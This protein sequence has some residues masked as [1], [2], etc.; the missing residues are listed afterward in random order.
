VRV[1]A[2]QMCCGPEPDANLTRAAELVTEAAHRD[3]RLV[4]LPELFAHLGTGTAMRAAAEPIDGPTTAWAAALA[5]RLGVHLD[6]TLLEAGDGGGV[7]NTQVVVDPTGTVTARYRK[8]HLFDVDVPGA[9][10]HESDVLTAGDEIVTVDVHGLIVGLSTCYDL[11][12]PELYRIL[13]LRG[14]RVLLVPSAFTA[15]TGP[16]HW[17]PLL[18]ARAIE[19]QAFVVAPDQCGTSPDGT[20]R[21][22]HS[23]I[24]DPWGRVV[25]EAGTEETVLVADLDDDEVS[26]TRAAVPSLANR[27]PSAYRWPDAS[28]PDE[29]GCDG[30]GPDGGSA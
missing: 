28:D 6:L 8:I 27:R 12:F 30:P 2:V 18:R 22:G 23:L 11:R 1:A 4:V 21:H 24:I 15:A 9:G 3:A 14:A 5:T 16:H 7:H 19:S 29:P 17:E 13:T 26:A 20:A 10:L 25:T